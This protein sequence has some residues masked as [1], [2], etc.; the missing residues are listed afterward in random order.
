MVRFPWQK[1]LGLLFILLMVSL[2]LQNLSGQSRPAAPPTSYTLFKEELRRGN[3]KQVT[4]TEQAVEGEFLTGVV[5]LGTDGKTLVF[6]TPLPPLADPELLPLL[7]ER[8]VEI[9]VD[10]SAGQQVWWM[11]L[12]NS[13]PWLLLLGFWMWTM[14]R[15]QGA[16]R[17]GPFGS[18]GQVKARVYDAQV[19]QVT[20]QD[21][22]GLVNPKR[23]LEEIVDFLRDPSKYQKIGGRVPRGVLLMGAPGTGKTLLARAMAGEA[24]VPF[25]STSASE[26]IEM[27]VGVGASRVRDLFEKARAK[28]PSIMFIDEID[29]VGRSRGAGLGGGNDEREQTL[30]QLL[31]EMDGFEGH[32]QVIVVAATN[33]PDVLDPAL[34]RPGRF[35]RQVVIDLPSLD[36]REAILKVHTRELPLAEDVELRLIARSSPGMSGADLAN[37]CNEAA[38][39][40]SRESADVVGPQHFDLAKDKVLMGIERPGLSDEAERRITAYHE[41]G[42]TLVARLIPG[43]DPVHKVTI[44][45]R[46]AAL[47]VTQ[48][49]PEGDRHYYPRAYLMGKLTVNMGG[50]AAELTVFE[51]T[52]TG[53][54]SDLKQS[55]DLAEKM[56]CQW[57]MSDKVGPVTFS[58]GEEHVFL[59]RKL[60]QEKTYSEQMGWIIDQEI[61]ELVRSGETRALELVREHRDALDRLAAALLER[62]ELA[63]GEIDAILSPGEERKSGTGS[64]R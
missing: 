49:V 28:A 54:Q 20:F 44:I 11:V 19:P 5:V 22:A 45:P 58:R 59:G 26:F 15:A 37:L 36:E 33:R 2:L 46:G 35:D 6:R 27:F 12:A 21:V 51:D 48:L 41:A 29:A 30:N 34:L 24:G 4:L 8:G 61:E 63:G 13:L 25:F 18:F 57:G 16:S 64:N 38:L 1:A 47:G 31:V 32:E 50:R 10:R 3:V 14:K 52:S 17:M 53:A 42:H 62:E 55:T 43:M 23:E 56:V 60:G 39:F 40:A 7:E 9:T